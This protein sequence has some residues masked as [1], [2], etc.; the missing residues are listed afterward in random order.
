MVISIET[1]ITGII[2]SR[3]L[4]EVQ[5][6]GRLSVIDKQRCVG[7]ALCVQACVRRQNLAGNASSCIAIRSNGG[8]KNGF[9]VIVCKACEDPP[10]AK[11]CPVDALRV[12]RDGG[13]ILDAARCIGCRNC[14]RACILNAVFWDPTANK[15]MICIH[16]GECAR[17]CPHGVLELERVQHAPGVEGDSGVDGE[18]KGEAG[19]VVHGA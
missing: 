7:C 6:M 4:L 11:V 5:F 2:V 15:P 3:Q 14:Q 13:V 19:E 18:T 10:C 12:R 1:V 17:F 16:C 8:M 9:K